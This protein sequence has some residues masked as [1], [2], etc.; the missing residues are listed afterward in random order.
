MRPS[1]AVRSAWP[2][3]FC[4]FRASMPVSRPAARKTVC[5]SVLSASLRSLVK[6]AEAAHLD[7]VGSGAIVINNSTAPRFRQVVVKKLLVRALQRGFVELS[8]FH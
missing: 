5:Q 3:E 8:L 6:N 2:I 7:E 4:R 1:G